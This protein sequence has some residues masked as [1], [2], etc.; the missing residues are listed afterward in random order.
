[1]AAA[2]SRGS[3]TSSN[4]SP[5]RPPICR[6]S[7]SVGVAIAQQGLRYNCAAVVAGGEIL[8]LVPKEKLPTYN[9]F[10]EGRTISR[11]LRE[12]GRRARGVPFGDLVFEFDFGVIGG[13]GLRG[14]LESRRA[15]AA[16]LLCRRGAGLQHLRLALSGSASSR[17]GA[18]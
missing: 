9:I 7:R 18:S 5:R 8:G 6:W 11:G 10:Y 17:P 12:H 1:M 13:R 3:G 14:P 15:D 2:S 16:P 4:D